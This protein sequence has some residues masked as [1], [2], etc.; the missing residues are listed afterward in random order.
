MIC[1]YRKKAA[2][3]V[4]QVLAFATVSAFFVFAVAL[5][6]FSYEAKSANEYSIEASLSCYVNAMGG[7]EFGEPLLTKAQLIVDENG[8]ESLKLHFTKSQVTIYNITCDTFIDLSPSSAANDRGVA[9]GTI[10]VYLSDGSL[11]T[12]DIS[13]TVSDDTAENASKKQVHYVDSIVFPI[14][15]RTDTYHLTM[16]INS[17]VMGVQF[18]DGN[19]KA[20]AATYPA[21]LTVNWE[22]LVGDNSKSDIK[23]NTENDE[24]ESSVA[25]EKKEGLNIHKASNESINIDNTKQSNFIAAYYNVPVIIGI[26]AFGGFMI[27][28]GAIFLIIAKK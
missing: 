10:G 18:C 25:V 6:A 20:D 16:Y 12:E 11:N 22:S 1:T 2:S 21:I 28:V 5:S 3:A 15:Q 14:D 9:N 24:T 13:Y 4:L 26:S 23:P 19:S 17:N 27:I 8:K 7:I